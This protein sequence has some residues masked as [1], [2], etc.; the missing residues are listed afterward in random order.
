M[1]RIDGD[2]FVLLAPGPEGL[3]RWSSPEGKPNLAPDLTFKVAQLALFLAEV[4]DC[5]Q[6]LRGDQL[7]ELIDHAIAACGFPA[8]PQA[9]A[10]LEWLFARPQGLS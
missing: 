3:E 7:E 2:K 10:A 6:L 4:E 5:A 1:P 8:S 9:R